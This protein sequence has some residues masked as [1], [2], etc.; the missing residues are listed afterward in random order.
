MAKTK[1][2]SK[3]DIVRRPPPIEAAESEWA[4]VTLDTL[5]LDGARIDAEVAGAIVDATLERTIEG[6]S[7]LTFLIQDSKR[8]IL[9]SGLLEQDKLDVKLT[10]T[11]Y[12][13]KAAVSKDGDVLTVTFEDRDIARLRTF[14]KPKKAAR[15]PKFTRAMFILSM[16]REVK[17]P[18]IKLYSPE[19]RKRQPIGKGGDVPTK[20][21]KDSERKAGFGSGRVT[22]KHKTATKAQKDVL[23]AVLDTALSITNVE[24]ALVA[25]VACVTQESV[26][27][28]ISKNIFQQNADWP[29]D[30][31]DA[32]NATRN[33]LSRANTVDFLTVLK[34][35][36]DKELGWQIDETQRSYTWNTAGQGKDFQQWVKEARHTVKLYGASTGESGEDKTVSRKKRYEFRR[37][38]PG[39]REDSWTAM[40][41]LAEEVNWRIFMVGDT[42]YFISEDDLYRSEPR[43]IL[44]EDDDGVD[45]IDFDVDSGKKVQEV[46][47]PCRTS[48]WEA[49]PGTVIKVEGCGPANGRYIVATVSRSLFST[50]SLITAK[51]PTKAKK[52]PAAETEKVTVQG[53]DK[54]SSS[55]DGDWGKPLSSLT[56]VTGKFGEARPGHTH[57][58][59]DIGKGIGTQVFAAKDGKVT[60]A[61]SNGGYGICIIIDHGNGLSSLYGHLSA[62]SVNVGK[63]VEKGDRIGKTGNTGHSFGPHLHFEVR[64]GGSPV[65]P[66]KYVEEFSK[67]ACT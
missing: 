58:G 38:Q 29:G 18:K 4:D 17:H 41:R 20:K 26:A 52:E 27:G 47:I 53:S 39:K 33:F 65:C 57:A 59:I 46:R 28:Q 12:F 49:P 9:Q 36:P 54:D 25:V 44:S 51:K 55:G 63:K 60:L 31:T 14:T 23:S 8:E 16:L 61:G 30:P 15:T 10:K 7:T 50:S 24:D 42:M 1:V 11:K 43:M 13:R 5:K 45:S 64:K 2:K 34:Q 32:A 66:A 56:P 3:N 21:E 37:G 19:L 6:A 67:G 48:M 62:L 35:H 40:K 22:V